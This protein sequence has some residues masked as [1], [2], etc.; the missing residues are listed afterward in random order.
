MFLQHKEFLKRA[1][2]LVLSRKSKRHIQQSSKLMISAAQ[3][4]YKGFTCSL[5]QIASMLFKTQV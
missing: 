1:L 3:L 5:K 4:I 2:G